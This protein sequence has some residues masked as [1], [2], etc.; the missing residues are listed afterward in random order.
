MLEVKFDYSSNTL[1]AGLSH[2]PPSLVPLLFPQMKAV[3]KSFEC[4]VRSYPGLVPFNTIN[5]QGH[6]KQVTVRTSSSGETL[7][8]PILHPQVRKG[9]GDQEKEKLEP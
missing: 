6:W 9:K 5:Q 7:V 1:S 4:F 8:W 2:R 3:V